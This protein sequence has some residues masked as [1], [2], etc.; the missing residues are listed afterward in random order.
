VYPEY[1][2]YAFLDG[3]EV[4][5]IIYI[6][7]DTKDRYVVDVSIKDPRGITIW[8]ASGTYIED[9]VQV[10]YSGRHKFYEEVKGFIEAQYGFYH[11]AGIRPVK[12]TVATTLTSVW[13]API[14]ITSTL[15]IARSSLATSI[16]YTLASHSYAMPLSPILWIAGLGI[17]LTGLLLSKAKFKYCLEC[18]K[19]IPKEALECPYCHAKQE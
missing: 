4:G 9:E 7:I 14:A 8:K 15:E 17:L 6:K 10:K 1:R 2:Y 16:S 3:L 18:G 13:Y 12:T 11:I 5:D 19:K